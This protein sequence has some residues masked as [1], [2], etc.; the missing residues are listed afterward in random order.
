LLSVIIVKTSNS[1]FYFVRD[2][3]KAKTLRKATKKN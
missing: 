3:S 2:V 1:I